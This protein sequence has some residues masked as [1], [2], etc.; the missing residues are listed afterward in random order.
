[1]RD[2]LCKT[3]LKSKQQFTM[4]K[5]LISAVMHMQFICN[6]NNQLPNLALTN[7]D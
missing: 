3:F 6:N 1:M 4:I 2:D 7:Q 5:N